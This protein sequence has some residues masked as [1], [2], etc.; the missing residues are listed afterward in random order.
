MKKAWNDEKEILNDEKAR[1]YE[2]EIL[3]D[4]E[5]TE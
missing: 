5:S 4:E 2:K 1:N 3:I